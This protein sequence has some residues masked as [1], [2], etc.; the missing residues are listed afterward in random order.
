MAHRKTNKVFTLPAFG[1][2]MTTLNDVY[3]LQKARE[4]SSEFYELE[5]AE[6]LEV[7]LDE[8]DIPDFPDGSKNYSLMGSIKARLIHDER[9]KD[10]EELQWIYPL[11]TNI[12][13]YP[14]KGEYVIVADYLYSR[15]YTQKL[16]INASVN[17]NSIPGISSNF[18]DIEDFSIGETFTVNTDIRQLWPY[19]G[20]ILFNGR[21][22]Q[23]IRFGKNGLETNLSPNIKISVGHLLD[24]DHAG[25]ASVK[26]DTESV[27]HKPIDENLD[28]DASSIWML[29]DEESTII[30]GYPSALIPAL[31]EGKQIILNSDKLIFNTKNGGDIGILSN[32]NVVI[33]A[34]TKMVVESPEIKLGSDDATEPIVLGDALLGLLEE[35]IDAITQTTV[36]TGVGP[37]GP[38]VN[39]AQ[40]AGIKTRLAQMLS[41]QNKTL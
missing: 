2:G 38:P 34:T 7:L 17:A 1:G 25:L 35:L 11:D 19:E 15:F 29:S 37:S 26:S 20:D 27:L 5:V 32:N 18:K 14:L 31:N 39:A 4:F 8:A 24:A 21:F 40:F 16:N 36:P 30:Q 10:I 33:G 23:G 41:P 13:E 28:A 12:K 22:G 3:K 6:V 9:G